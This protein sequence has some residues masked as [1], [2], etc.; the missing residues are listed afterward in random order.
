MEDAT[1][2]MVYRKF[3]ASLLA[4]LPGLL[5]VYGL[6]SLTLFLLSD[7]AG[8]AWGWGIGISAIVFALTLSIW[9][10]VGMAI[11]KW[12][13]DKTGTFLF[14]LNSPFIL[15]WIA[16]MGWLFWVSVI[17]A[18]RPGEADEGQGQHS[19]LVVEHADSS[20]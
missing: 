20:V 12:A 5:L 4:I 17:N 9:L 2:V 8:I 10:F 15:I 11:Q 3:F 16:I 13:E 1:H 6:F 18:S 14:A 19:A 7:V